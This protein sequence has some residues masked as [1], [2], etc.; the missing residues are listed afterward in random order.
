MAKLIQDIWILRV[1]G[2]VVFHR[3]FNPHLDAQLFG[4]LMTSLNFFAE[5]LSTGGLS[6]FELSNKRF[7]I[8]K[9]NKF[10]FIANSSKDKKAKKV[11]Q[12]LNAIV[13]KFFEKYSEDILCD[14]SG[15]INTFSDFDEEIENSLEG[16]IRKFQKAF[17]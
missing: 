4:G 5:E 6:N 8:I 14:F 9:K 2:I 17:W 12:E 7:S 3:V 13:T 15:N 1:S 16:T 10:L 11:Q